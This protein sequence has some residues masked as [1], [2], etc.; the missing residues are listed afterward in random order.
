MMLPDQTQQRDGMALQAWLVV[1][2]ARDP[3]L[4]QSIYQHGVTPDF[5]FLYQDTPLQ[6]LLEY[7]PILLRL[8]PDSLLWPLL[9]QPQWQQNALVIWSAQCEPS[10]L[11][12]HLRSLLFMTI[13]HSLT[14]V[15]FY[16]P[17]TFHALRQS[18]SDVRFEQ[19]SGPILGWDYSESTHWQHVA[20]E[21][22]SPFV[23]DQADV[24]KEGWF[25]L[26]SDEMTS[27]NNAFL[28]G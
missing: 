26:S 14:L 5:Q 16:S 22:G 24:R 23:D 12:R 2:I 21:R 7:S 15:R 4:L 10:A 25:A 11:L 27:F 13:D 8:T 19:L 9:E 28:R 1:D 6:T 18:L 3:Y 20:I 17:A